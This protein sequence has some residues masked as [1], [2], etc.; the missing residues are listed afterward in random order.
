M[1]E[2]YA[3]KACSA[4]R[5][6]AS[7]CASCRRRRR[8]ISSAATAPERDDDRADPDRRRRA[9]RRTPGRTRSRR[10][11]RRPRPAP[12]RRRRRR[13]R[14]SRCW[15]PRPGPPPRGR[16]AES[17]TFATGAKKSPI[18]IPERTNGTTSRRT[19]RS[20]TPTA[21]IQPRPTAWSASPS[22]H[23]RPPADPVGERA[24]DRG[25]EDRHRRPRQ[26]PQAR[27]GRA[28]S[29]APSGRTGR[30]GRSSRTSRRTSAATRGSSAANV[31][32]RKK[33]IGS[34]GVLVR[35]SQRTNAVTR[36]VPATSDV[37]ISGLDQPWPFPRT[38]PQ[39]IPSRP[40]LASAT[41]GRSS[42]FDGPWLS[43][44]RRSAS[45]IRTRPSGTL[46]QKIHCQ[47]RPE[48]TAPPTSG[49]SATAR[50]PIPP[51]A[52]SARPRFSAGTAAE[53]IVSVSG[54]M[55]APPTPWAAR[56]ATSASIEG[57]S[58]AAAEAAVKIPSPIANMRRRPKRSPS[59]APVRR[60]TAKVSV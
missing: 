9:R 41:P 51:Q 8:G 25:D 10:S 52:P 21:A 20:A 27:P 59:A 24:R 42:L 7:W 56:A 39:T 11:G 37:T 36:T 50:P 32:L 29:P 38:R 46:I 30:A 19:A 1:V 12:R 54:A 17:T 60:N 15:R 53:R 31:R 4:S 40:R 55:I 58:A 48:T 23:E 34:I 14:G 28:S 33:R 16:T 44:R 22:G 18:P 26:D 47:E 57:A 45:G 3:G 49:P 43:S 35:S 5:S 13:A 2:K 6:S